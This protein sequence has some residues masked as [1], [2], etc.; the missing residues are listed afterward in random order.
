M[1]IL[2]SMKLRLHEIINT[3]LFAIF[4]VFGY[5]VVNGTTILAKNNTS[6]LMPDWEFFLFFGLAIL[7]FA[8][9]VIY[10]VVFRK[11]YKPSIPMLILFGTLFIAGLLTLLSFESGRSFSFSTLVLGENGAY[12]YDGP[13][14]TF[15]YV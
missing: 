7:F 11:V 2:T 1:I 15:V 14:S 12:S 9:F 6:G 4:L 5:V 3:L 8:A 10:N 13:I